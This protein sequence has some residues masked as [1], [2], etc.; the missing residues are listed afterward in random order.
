[1]LPTDV[2]TVRGD[3]ERFCGG[4]E[5]FVIAD[6]CARPW[7]R[8]QFLRGTENAMMD[9]A[10][11]DTDTA[12]LLAV[13]HEYYLREMEFWVSTAVDAVKFM[14]DWGS[15]RQLLIAPHT[16]RE[17]FKPLYRDYCDLAHA[18]GKFIFMHS[19]GYILDI[20]E[21]LIELGVD[22]INSQ[23]F[24]MD[25]SKVAEIARGRIA[26]W[27]EIDRQQILPSCDP[28]VGRAAVRD[29]AEHLWDPAGGMIAQLEFGLGANPETVWAVYEEWES[30]ASRG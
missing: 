16:W 29:L 1:V 28:S 20:Y 25:W 9:I 17:L 23:L 6:A 5:C 26:F 24:C 22:A 13:I 3:V 10:S 14:D 7:E 30:V 12:K 27:G 18:H 21:D 15:Q 11:W 19:D 2:V 4:T 8:Y